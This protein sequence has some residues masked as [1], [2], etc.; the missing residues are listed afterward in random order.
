LAASRRIWLVVTATPSLPP[1][2]ATI[3][4]DPER[5]R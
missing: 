2:G 5:L 1:N 4:S 3:A